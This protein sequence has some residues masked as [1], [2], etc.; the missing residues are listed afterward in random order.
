MVDELFDALLVESGELGRGA[1]RDL[2]SGAAQDGGPEQGGASDRTGVDLY[3]DL[4]CLSASVWVGC[5]RHEHGRWRLLGHSVLP[6]GIPETDETVTIATD[7]AP[8]PPTVDALDAWLRSFIAAVVVTL[9]DLERLP[10]NVYIS[11]ASELLHCIAKLAVEDLLVTCSCETCR[12]MAPRFFVLS[13]DRT[14]YV[15]GEGEP[16]RESEVGESEER[17]A[18]EDESEGSTTEVESDSE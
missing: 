18:E 1:M 3:I 7:G 13:A 15:P 16:E 4:G 17:E 10:T 8:P 2:G 11:S 14:E 6:G 12:K 9:S 5:E